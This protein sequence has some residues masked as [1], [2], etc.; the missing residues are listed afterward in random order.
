MGS[1]SRE[2][3]NDETRCAMLTPM[4]FQQ[5]CRDLHLPAETV[6][7]IAHIRFSPPARRVQGRAGNMSGL[8][9]SKKMGVT[10]QFE[11]QSVE[12]GA[13]Y[14]MDHDESVLELYDQPHT[15]KLRYLDQSGKR[16]QGHYYTPDFLVVRKNGAV[17]EEWKTEEELC[18]LAQ[19]QPYR[20][21]RG[22]DGIWRCPPG[23]EG[24][25]SIGLSLRVCSSAS[26]PRTYID[27][28]DFLADYFIVPPRL[29]ET[30]VSLI[31]A[32]IQESPGITIAALLGGPGG[33][34]ANDVY[35]LIALDQIFTDLNVSS[36]RDHFR[37]RLYAD[38]AT[39][40][41]YAQLGP[42]SSRLGGQIALPASAP[43]STNTRLL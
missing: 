12:L 22:E 14:L 26:L 37:T 38:Q 4:Q 8:F 11:S 13:L 27:N 20:Y 29:P 32:R 35:A 9:P 19:K 41:A 24:A 17:F 30:V 15:F 2:V 36:L 7:L 10:I 28:L 6:D 18:T 16:M 31:Q 1:Q 34:R 23:E 42:V 43:L 5:W 3:R 25:Q 39:A 21:Q 40:F 33:L